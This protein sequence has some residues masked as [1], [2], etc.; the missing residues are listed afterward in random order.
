MSCR[1]RNVGFALVA[2][3]NRVI[4]AAISRIQHDETRWAPGLGQD[5]ETRQGSAVTEVSDLVD[6]SAW[7][8][9]TRLIARR[10]PLH[11]GAQTTLFPSL[12]YRYWGHY[13]DAEGEPVDLDAHMRAHAHVED[14]IRRLKDSGLCRFPFADLDANRARLAVVCFADALVRWFQLLCLSGALAVAD[15]RPRA[16]GR[17][18][19]A[20]SCTAPGGALCASLTAGPPPPRCSTPYQRIALITERPRLRRTRASLRRHAVRS[21]LRA[22]PGPST[23]LRATASITKWAVHSP[24]GAEA[25]K[26]S[27]P[28][29]GHLLNDRVRC[30]TWPPHT[31]GDPAMG[32][33]V[34]GRTR[35]TRVPSPSEASLADPVGHSTHAGG[36]GMR[37]DA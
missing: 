12:Q 27:A 29:A 19:P 14:H 9:G 37:V 10:E 35:A 13:T 23:A 31:A 8:P 25:G 7:P 32:G 33:D 2:R 36:K 24:G 3:S 28:V 1:D 16:A 17:H 15:P 6:L 30:Q 20:R 5:G 22:G 26:T 18:A 34:S 4:H 11:P 21:R